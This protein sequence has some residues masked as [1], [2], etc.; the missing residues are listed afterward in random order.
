MPQRIHSFLADH[1]RAGYCRDCLAM[2]LKVPRSTVDALV[3]ALVG[4]RA[5]RATLGPCAGCDRVAPIVTQRPRV[6]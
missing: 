4:D 5:L 3:R 1:P 6:L 2:S